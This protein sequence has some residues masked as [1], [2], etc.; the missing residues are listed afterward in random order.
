MV[1]LKHFT[2]NQDENKYFCMLSFSFNHF[3]QRIN[4]LTSPNVV[5]ND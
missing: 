4:D 3:N 1:I 5:S 2:G